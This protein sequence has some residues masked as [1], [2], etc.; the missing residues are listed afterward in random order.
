MWLVCNFSTRSK[1]GRHIWKVSVAFRMSDV[2]I[3]AFFAYNVYNN[4]N[5]F[6][7]FY[8]CTWDNL[9]NYVAWITNL[10]N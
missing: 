7:Y 8:F 10:L 3:L 9:S 5:L 1:K 4:S 6:R 2:T